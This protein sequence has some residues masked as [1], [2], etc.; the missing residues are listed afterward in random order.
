MA[1]LR[2]DLLVRFGKWN[3]ARTVYAS[4]R[5]SEVDDPEIDGKILSVSLA[6][7]DLETALPIAQRL[8]VRDP[9]YRLVT[10]NILYH[11]RRSD[12]ALQELRTAS[13]QAVQPDRLSILFGT[14]MLEN[15]DFKRA[16]AYLRNQAAMTRHPDIHTLLGRS[17]SGQGRHDEAQTIFDRATS[18]AHD[19][20]NANFWR[21]QER[22]KLGLTHSAP[23][24]P[25][26]GETPEAAPDDV[27]TFFVADSS[28]F[29]QHGVV[30]LGSMGR[31]SPGIKCHV[32]VI[33]PDTGV[34]P[35]IEAIRDLL[36]GLRLSF[37]YELNDFEGRSD[38][39]VRTY[40]A[41][42]RFVRL[43]E[44]FARA[45]A[46]YLSLDADCIVRGEIG[47]DG[48]GTADIG[49]RMRFDERPHAT[50]AAGALRLRP[51]EA[52][53]TVVNRVAG[54]IRS[55]LETGEAVWFLDQIVLSHA[56]R[57]LGDGEITIDQLSMT[58]IDWFFHDESLI[59]TGKGPR[60]LADTRYADELSK[61][62][63]ILDDERI[64]AL[65]PKGDDQ[66][67]ED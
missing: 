52:A 12:E 10:A 51:T 17:L 21:T 42:V 22:I 50:V 61:Y 11:L 37:S 65:T 34:A 20:P 23:L 58:Y 40:Y 6:M 2:G 60:K 57:E 28:Y 9:T 4:L 13:L 25:L 8:A 1:M 36:P 31:R 24:P 33:N 3:E 56:L 35:A 59:W 43:A 44:I 30:L 19:D 55:T 63:Y 29:W 54:L 67:D 7:H 5:A 15:G 48:L 38:D 16:E 53:A 41:S 26:V 32:H 49:V 47:A 46:T 18:L 45:P 64:S 14:L 27:V 62:R 39:Y 66:S